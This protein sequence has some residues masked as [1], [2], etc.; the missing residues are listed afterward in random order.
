MKKLFI[1]FVMLPFMA[2]STNAQ[3][4]LKGDINEDGAVDI[5]DVVELVNIILNGSNIQSYL[6][7]PDDHHPHLIDLGLPS[8][9]KW[10][11]C[12][13]GAESPEDYGGYYAWGETEEKDWY[14]RDTYI[15]NQNGSYVNLGEIAG[16]QYDVVHVKWG[17]SW[18]MPSKEQLNEL[19]DN[20]TPTWTRVNNVGGRLLT[21]NIKGNSIFLPAAGFRSNGNLSQAGSNGYYWSSS[22]SGSLEE[23]AVD[24]A[25]S[26]SSNGWR[27]NIDG[28]RHRGFSVRPVVKQ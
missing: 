22:Q 3:S 25:F 24:I 16:T 11:C 2:V 1:L 27:W 23:Y 8:G 17:G 18:V 28:R 14:D 21:S 20:C 10:A 19:L 12:N 5:S 13:V 7:C 6:T 15:H 4:N 9:T 26:N